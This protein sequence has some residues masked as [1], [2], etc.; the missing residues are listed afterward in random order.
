MITTCR[1]SKDRT[2]PATVVTSFD[3][4]PLS[5]MPASQEY[6]L[7]KKKKNTWNKKWHIVENLKKLFLVLQ[8]RLIVLGTAKRGLLLQTESFG[9]ETTFQMIMCHHYSIPFLHWSFKLSNWNSYI[10]TQICSWQY[11]NF[12]SGCEASITHGCVSTRELWHLLV[13][14]PPKAFMCHGEEQPFCLMQGQS[15]WPTPCQQPT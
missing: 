7:I 1:Y 10:K 14:H 8:Q 11:E 13:K 2:A 6:Y 5:K 15:R 12:E 3:L 4:W 9:L